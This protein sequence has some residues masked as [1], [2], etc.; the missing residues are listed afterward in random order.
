VICVSAVSAFAH[1]VAAY[2]TLVILNF[3]VC[4]RGLVALCAASA[5]VPVLLSVVFP[6]IAELTIRD[7][8]LTAMVT[9][10]ICVITVSA[11]AHLVAT[12]VTLVILNFYV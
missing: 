11:R 1:L 7:A 8:F 12:S 9:A 10:V 4:V 3:H 5:F 2:V 6:S